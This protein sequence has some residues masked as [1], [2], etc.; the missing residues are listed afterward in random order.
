[1]EKILLNVGFEVLFLTGLA[2]LYYFYQKN[3]I[4]NGPPRWREKKLDELHYLATNCAD[5]ENFQDIHGFLDDIEHRLS[6]NLPIDSKFLNCW[7]GKSLPDAILK[8]LSECQ[9]WQLHSQPKT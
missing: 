2:L 8:I 4:L 3:R 1:M 9:E 7:L 5:P 6:N